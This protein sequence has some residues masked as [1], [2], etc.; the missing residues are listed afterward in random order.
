M[1]LCL[2][3]RLCTWI[4]GAWVTDAE[5]VNPNHALRRIICSN[6]SGSCSL[7][8]GGP[9]AC[10]TGCNLCGIMSIGCRDL[11]PTTNESTSTSITRSWPSLIFSWLQTTYILWREMTI[12]EMSQYFLYVLQSCCNFVMT[13]Q[14][15]LSNSQTTGEGYISSD[16]QHVSSCNNA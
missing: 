1:V 6:Y 16:C 2:L 13:L 12:C 5:V 14:L 10:L 15:I 8:E 9:H 7:G 3:D 11:V 4:C